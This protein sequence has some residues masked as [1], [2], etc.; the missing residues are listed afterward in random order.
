ML[1]GSAAHTDIFPDVCLCFWC[2]F[3]CIPY[4][5]PSAS[6][7]WAPASLIL[8]SPDP[9]PD[10]DTSLGK[11]PI[12]MLRW[13]SKAGGQAPALEKQGLT[14]DTGGTG[15]MGNPSTAW[16]RKGLPRVKT[17]LSIWWDW[18]TVGLL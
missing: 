8:L 11:K 1:A 4:S 15:L 7:C 17:G 18:L 14:E 3:H 2:S 6:P 5:S 10:S 12:Y 9:Q 16:V 13:C